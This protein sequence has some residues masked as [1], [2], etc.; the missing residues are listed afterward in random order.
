MLIHFIGGP[1]HGHSQV[2]QNPP[3][4]IYRFPE[5][6]PRAYFVVED[7]Y[8]TAEA[9]YNV[10]QYRVTKQTPRYAI[11]EWE[12]ERV[13]VHFHVELAVDPNDI[14]AGEAL[15]DFML[16]RRDDQKGDVK[17]V[18]GESWSAMKVTLT[19]ATMVDGPRDAVALQLAAEKVQ[20]YLDAKLPP[21]IDPA[22]IEA[23]TR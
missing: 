17:C 18:A 22:A 21:G 4:P 13:T 15:R 2:T 16:G 5:P 6:K 23:A 12:P 14:T 20:Q 9:S 10:S 1:Q 11:A 8:P 19:L 3:Q 7:Y